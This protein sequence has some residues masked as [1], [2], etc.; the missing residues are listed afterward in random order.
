MNRRRVTS[1]CTRQCAFSG[2]PAKPYCSVSSAANSTP[3]MSCEERR[4]A[5]GSKRYR[6]IPRCLTSLYKLGGSMKQLPRTPP[7]TTH[8]RDF[9]CPVTILRERH[10]F[11]GRVLLALGAVHRRGV[12]LLLVVLPDGSRSLIPAGWTDLAAMPVAEPTAATENDR[13]HSLARLVDFLRAR[14]IL[15]A[16]LSR[17]SSPRSDPATTE[18]SCRATDSGASRAS[19]STGNAGR[20][21]RPRSPRQSL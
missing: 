11:E 3:S 20:A 17:V 5:C 13:H 4:K 14:T 21:A 2:S 18:E 10:P 9:P 7:H 19:R 12:A 16:L 6:I 8:L 15:D 1:R